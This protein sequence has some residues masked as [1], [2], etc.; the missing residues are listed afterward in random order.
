VAE[1]TNTASRSRNSMQ[2]DNGSISKT[3][4]T[5]LSLTVIY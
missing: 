3:A 1:D 2:E 4:F 5:K